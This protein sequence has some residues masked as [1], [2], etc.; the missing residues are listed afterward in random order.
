MS[1]G[2]HRDVLSE[3]LKGL[4]HLRIL[5][6]DVLKYSSSSSNLVKTFLNLKPLSHYCV[7]APTQHCC[8]RKAPGKYTCHCG[9]CAAE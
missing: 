9:P 5:P 7:S 1:A 2:Y 3:T 6:S 4:P 8:R